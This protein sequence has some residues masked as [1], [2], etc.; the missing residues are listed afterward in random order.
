MAKGARGGKRAKPGVKKTQQSLEDYLNNGLVSP[1]SP[2]LSFSDANPNYDKGWEYQEN[3]QRC[4]WAYELR[5]RGYDVEALPTFQGDTL[6][7]HGNWR[8]LGGLGRDYYDWIG[9]DNH[10]VTRQT[11]AI[12]DKMIEWG[13][14]SRAIVSI[15]WKG[16]NKTNT[17]HVFNIE[18]I[19]GKVRAFDAQSGEEINIKDY[20]KN[21]KMDNTF[22]YR[23]DTAKIDTS[24]ASKYVK[25]KGDK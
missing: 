15:A 25:I 24:K 11:K 17:G 16:R 21:A 10:N 22:I 18:N 6:P 4:V 9:M 19:G 1:L 8:D 13:D 2:E 5:R 14:G 7:K 12:N 23:T 20:L 3:C